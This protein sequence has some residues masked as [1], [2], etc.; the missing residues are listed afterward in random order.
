MD[1]GSK[2]YAQSVILNTQQFD[3]GSQE[4]LKEM[5]L[6][7]FGLIVALNRDKDYHRLRWPFASIPGFEQ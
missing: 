3:A 4:R 2:S 1:D 7:Q 6:S 5:L